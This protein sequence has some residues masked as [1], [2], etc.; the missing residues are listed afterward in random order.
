MMTVETGCSFRQFFQSSD[1][2]RDNFLA[3]VVGL[4]N[5]EPIRIW[6]R[7]PDSPYED[8]GRPTVFEIGKPGRGHTL[9][10][11]LR[12]RR[13]GRVFVAEM[14]CEITYENYRSMTLTTRAQ[15]DRHA[16]DSA[17]FSKFLAVAQDPNAFRVTVGGRPIN[18][19]GVILI[20]GACTQDGRKDVVENTDIAKVLSLEEIIETLVKRED[21]AYLGL[22]QKR[23]AWCKELFA[24]LSGVSWKSGI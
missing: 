11:T 2:Q 5:E 4:F 6:C 19:D 1:P 18:V 23:M 16:R 13:D 14:K 9:D 15:L 7:E 8:L 17:A 22:V 20:W 10:F 12:S 21:P 24:F 3:R